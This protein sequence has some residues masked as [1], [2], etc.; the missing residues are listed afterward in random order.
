MP[1]YT[2][3]NI[4]G[5]SLSVLVAMA[6]IL[7]DWKRRKRPET[8]AEWPRKWRYRYNPLLY[9][10]SYAAAYGV[11]SLGTSLAARVTNV[12][13][14]AGRLTTF[15]GSVAFA[16]GVLLFIPM[17]L[18]MA[19]LFPGNGRP[20]MQLEL[21]LPSLALNH[22][23]N[24]IACLLGGCCYGV[25]CAFGIIY[26]DAAEASAHYGAGTRLFPNLPLESLSMLLCF[27]LLLF[28]HY[29]GKRT[30]PIFPLVFGAA[31]LLLGFGMSPMHEPL[32]PFFGFLYPT[33]LLHLLVFF[34]GILFLALFVRERR[35]AK[36]SAAEPPPEQ[37]EPQAE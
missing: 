1:A 29:R 35:N 9:L 24:R 11:L 10:L 21:V 2:T 7:I 26:P 12:T 16:S 37:A 17:F 6:M 5:I 34:I 13:V 4:F 18:L 23:F 28:L 15:N 3:V 20:L 30:L 25:P 36:R 27:A 19:R 22:V 14:V 33:Q 8:P 31:G 32:R